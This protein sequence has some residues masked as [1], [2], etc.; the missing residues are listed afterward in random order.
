MPLY[1]Y[2][3]T[4]CGHSFEL[5]TSIERRDEA[6]CP[7]CGAKGARTYRGKCAFGAKRSGSGEDAS[8]GGCSCGGHCAG[9]SGCGH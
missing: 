8:G 7:K 6:A 3:C 1:S 5:L 4:Q 2:K 9:C